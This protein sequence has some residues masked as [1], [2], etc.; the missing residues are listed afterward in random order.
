MDLWSQ[1]KPLEEDYAWQLFNIADDPS[2][3][4]DL[5]ADDLDKLS[6][7]IVLW[8]DTSVITV[9]SFRMKSPAIDLKIYWIAGSQLSW[10]LVAAIGPRTALTR[11]NRA[12]QRNSLTTD[13]IWQRARSLF[14]L[15]LLPNSHPAGK[16]L[17]STES[18]HKSLPL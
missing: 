10:P 16:S 8:G 6:E 14:I 1:P 12:C 7:L 5:A 11:R 18:R 17:E 3:I 2:E 15:I 9:S 13:R 4:H